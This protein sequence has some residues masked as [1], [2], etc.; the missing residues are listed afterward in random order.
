MKT[1]Y[2]GTNG[3]S[4][5]RSTDLGETLERM[6]ST[7]GLYSGSRVWALL[8]TRRGLLAGTDSGIYCWDPDSNFWIPLPSPIDCQ[9]ITALASAPNNP[10]V[11]LAGSQPGAI[12][13]VGGCGAPLVQPGCS[14]CAICEQWLS[15]TPR[16]RGHKKQCSP[17]SATLDAH[18][19]DYL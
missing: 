10:D 8:P 17:T 1:L 11:L 4:V 3:L 18:Y 19:A 13:P 12:L 6:P 2:I 7:T 16:I 14:D 5:W 9:V 15:R